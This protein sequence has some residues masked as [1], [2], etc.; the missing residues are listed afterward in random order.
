[1]DASSFLP[2]LNG[3]ALDLFALYKEVAAR[4]GH[5]VGNGINWSGQVFPALRNHRDVRQAVV[6]TADRGGEPAL[7]AYVVPRRGSAAAQAGADLLDELLTL[8]PEE[9][10]RVEGDEEWSDGDEIAVAI[11]GRPTSSR[12]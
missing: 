11:V 3:K 10:E 5:R 12:G 1:M 4:G 2:V 6:V 8:I 9:T 7:V